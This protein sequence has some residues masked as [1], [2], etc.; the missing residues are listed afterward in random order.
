[1]AEG[2]LHDTENPRNSLAALRDHMYPGSQ[3]RP[4]G[5]LGVVV[6]LLAVGLMALTLYMGIFGTLGQIGTNAVHLAIAIPLVFLLHPAR[7]G[8]QHVD[9]HRLRRL[10]ALVGSL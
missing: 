3:R 7:K 1:M 2:Y 8:A 4:G 5:V 9:I 10:K 6:T